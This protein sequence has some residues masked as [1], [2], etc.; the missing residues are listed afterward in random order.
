MKIPFLFLASLTLSLVPCRAD[1]ATGFE[2]PPYTL[3]ATIV[4]VDGWV[5]AAGKNA[6][7]ENGLIVK[8]PWDEEKAVLR[9]KR[10]AV[11]GTGVSV[12]NDSFAPLRGIV[13]VTAGLAFDFNP[14][15]T[16]DTGT[17]LAFTQQSVKGGPIQ[18]GAW[19]GATDGGLY[20]YSASTGL[21]VVF[22][23]K[24]QIKMNSL[25]EFKLTISL[26]EQRFDL[27]VTGERAD[28]TPLD[29]FLTDLSSGAFDLVEGSPALSLVYI[30]NGGNANFVSYLDHLSLVAIP[31]PGSMALLGMGVLGITLWTAR[32]SKGKGIS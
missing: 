10:G 17:T 29:V 12:V 24:D 18:V 26:E 9:L 16:S 28:G 23:P 15:L 20:Y 25:Y 4:N 22:L 31:E 7:L 5:A 14:T 19:H 8:A 11:S 1:Y 2:V 32:R 27:R 13:E 6:S 3:N 30:G 21:R